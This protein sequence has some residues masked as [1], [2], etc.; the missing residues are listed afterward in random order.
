MQEYKKLWVYLLY[1]KPAPK[2]LVKLPPCHN[3]KSIVTSFRNRLNVFN[4]FEF[5]ELEES[6]EF[7]CLSFSVPEMKITKRQ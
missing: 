4:I 5:V 1:E 2:M 6:R 3:N 7:D